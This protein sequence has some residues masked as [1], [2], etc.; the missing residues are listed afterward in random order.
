MFC[1]QYQGIFCSVYNSQLTAVYKYIWM[2]ECSGL[3]EILERRV[4]HCLLVR[5]IAAVWMIL[6]GWLDPEQSKN[7][8]FCKKKDIQKY[9]DKDQLFEHMVAK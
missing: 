4:V 6:K 8:H 9:I 3:H 5:L 2:C 1:D 7:T